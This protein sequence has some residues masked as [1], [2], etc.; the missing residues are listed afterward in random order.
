MATTEEIL[1]WLNQFFNTQ[2]FK[3][4]S[5]DFTLK[6]LTVLILSLILLFFFTSRLSRFLVKKV[7]P[8][9]N[10]NIG[11]SEAIA[12]IIRYILIIIGLYII[13]Q[14]TGIDLSAL[15]LL[16]GALGVGIGFGLQNITS[17]FISGIIILFERPVKVGDRVE[18]DGLNGNI[19]NISARAT[20]VLTNDNI[21][22][23][24]PNSDFIN[25][26]VINWSL[27]N[28]QIRINMEV[29]VA[30]KED[31]FVVREILLE[32]VNKQAGVL[33]TP[34]PY[35]RFDGFGDSSIDFTLQFWT[36]EYIKKPL[37]LKSE[38]YYSIFRAFKEKKIEI[39][40]PQRDVYIRK[41]ESEQ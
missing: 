12:T 35:V 25:S 39:P 37:I 5:S 36:T 30:Y 21:A 8:K 33:L 17:N 20:T 16:L 1:E 10:M 41:A 29:G 2:L 34:E 40:F 15:G 3:L 27:T 32:V 38:I 23:V 14:S 6:T 24:V 9:Y 4:G 19:T 13:L 31:P 11:V 22:V 26:R 18:I 7:F 28:N